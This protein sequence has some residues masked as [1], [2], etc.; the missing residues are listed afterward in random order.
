MFMSACARFTICIII[1]RSDIIHAQIVTSQSEVI[2]PR[3][4]Y[5]ILNDSKLWTDEPIPIGIGANV[6]LKAVGK[7]SMLPSTWNKALNSIVVFCVCVNV[8]LLHSNVTVQWKWMQ[9][10]LHAA[11]LYNSVIF[12]QKFSTLLVFVSAI[13]QIQQ[14]EHRLIA[15]NIE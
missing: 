13:H 6:C 4:A 9:E 8:S 10:S 11:N 5:R 3:M 2:A 12:V 15:A 7:F 1:S 14:F